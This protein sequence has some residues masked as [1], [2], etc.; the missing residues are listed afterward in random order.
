[1]ITKEQYDVFRFN[2]G[3]KPLSDKEW[4]KWNMTIHPEEEVLYWAIRDAIRQEYNFCYTMYASVPNSMSI[5]LVDELLFIQSGFF[6]FD[7]YC[8]KTKDF[9]WNLAKKEN[10]NIYTQIEAAVN[11]SSFPIAF[12]KK[13]EQLTKNTVE[14]IKEKCDRRQHAIDITEHMIHLINKNKMDFLNNETENQESWFDEKLSYYDKYLLKLDSNLEKQQELL[15]KAQQ[16]LMDN[17]THVIRFI[18]RTPWN[19]LAYYQSL[20]PKEYFKKR[21]QIIKK[22]LG[23]KE[24]ATLWNNL[25]RRDTSLEINEYLEPTKDSIQDDCKKLLFD[26]DN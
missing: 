20:I 2:T 4:G 21:N 17:N 25:N 8:T 22:D 11:D 10:A 24:Y 9:I 13:C 12:Q 7:G 26:Y 14:R 19:D 18:N 3:D 6:C 23:K 16:E 1:M 15:E 5:E